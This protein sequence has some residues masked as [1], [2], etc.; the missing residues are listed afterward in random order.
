MP[1]QRH[2]PCSLHTF[3]ILALA[4]CQFFEALARHVDIEKD[5]RSAQ[6]SPE[7]AH[8]G[9]QESH[10]IAAAQ[11]R[12]QYNRLVRSSSTFNS[13]TDGIS[14][15]TD[16]NGN[17]D[18]KLEGFLQI[19]EAPPKLLE[20]R[21]Y[22]KTV[23]EC[24][25]AGGPAP[26]VTWYKDGR[27]VVK[28]LKLKMPRNFDEHNLNFE[29]SLGETVARLTIDCVTEK[30]AGL[31]E[32][33]AEN[34]KEQVSVGTVL[35]VDSFSGSTECKVRSRSPPTIHS[36]FSTY[37]QTI[38]SSGKLTCSSQGSPVTRWIAPNDQEIVSGSKYK[39]LPNGDLV[40]F[41]LSFEDMG[42]FQCKVSNNY[43][44]DMKETFVYPLAVMK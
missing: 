9:S 37:I 6:V 30:D 43:G 35:K 2:H 23:L 34:S 15:N 16:D 20:A 14:G 41:D 25:A 42:M 32:C 18:G 1:V 31:Y 28:D 21:K 40:I 10:I 27:P 29:D 24:S 11:P 36:W 38:G 3:F 44:H 17:M 12:V 22:G 26:K 13:G 39:I 33:V 7:T 19:K 8:L 5:W 4:S